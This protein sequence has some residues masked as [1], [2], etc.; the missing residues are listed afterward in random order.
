MRLIGLLILWGLFYIRNGLE[1]LFI[2]LLNIEYRLTNFECKSR[3]RWRPELL[4]SKFV[5]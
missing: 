3:A 5:N 2:R 1:F 4:H